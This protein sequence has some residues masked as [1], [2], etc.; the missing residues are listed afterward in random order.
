MAFEHG[1]LELV[2]PHCFDGL[3]LQPHAE[4][5][6]QAH[7]LRVPLRIDDELD[8]NTA[9]VICLASFI[10]ELRLNGVNEERCAHASTH[11][12]QAASIA[13]AAAWA[14]SAAAARA[15]ATADALT[16]SGTAAF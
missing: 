4:M 8:R 12:H 13:A 1:C 14:T 2:L 3:F 5:T 16:K 6:G 10:R 11:A 9:L 7:V 15:Y